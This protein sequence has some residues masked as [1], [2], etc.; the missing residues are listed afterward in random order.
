MTDNVTD[1]FKQEAPTS[2]ET[3]AAPV[4]PEA[5]PAQPAAPV[6]PTIASEFVGEG[7]K[8]SS[9]EVALGAIPHAQEHIT[10]LEAENARLREAVDGSTKLEDALSRIE[11]GNEQTATPA[12]P[13]YDPAKMR[14]EARSVYQEIGE[15][16]RVQANIDKA[17]AEIG[18]LYGDKAPEV[19]LAAAQAMGVSVEFLKSTAAKSPAAFI[20]LVSGNSGQSGNL[21]TSN[22]STINSE[23]INR[24]QNLDTP[25]AKVASGA[26]S[27]DLVNGWR[28]AGQ[29]VANKYN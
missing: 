27:K 6:V 18:R 23:A 25:T 22:E 26:S 17:N 3:P 10:N 7:K 8:Y 21:P 15:A 5:A 20:K 9:V 24:N 1:V 14:E 19:T 4:T 16:D 11:A 13:E 28:A 29:I 12:T 2:V